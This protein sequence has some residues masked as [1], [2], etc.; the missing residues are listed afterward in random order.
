MNE[1]MCTQNVVGTG[2]VACCGV[3]PCF[4]LF[5]RGEQVH[6]GNGVALVCWWDWMEASLLRKVTP[7]DGWMDYSQR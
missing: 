5:R 3:D 1:Y 7:L 4:A 6:E 2:C